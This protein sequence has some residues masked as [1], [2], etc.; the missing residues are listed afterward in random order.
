MRLLSGLLLGSLCLTLRA[1]VERLDEAPEISL[2][3]MVWYVP[4]ESGQSGYWVDGD[5]NADYR[6]NMGGV[7]SKPLAGTQKIDWKGREF[8]VT[9]VGRR[10]DGTL[11]IHFD[12]GLLFLTPQQ[13][14]SNGETIWQG[15]Y[16]VAGAISSPILFRTS[17]KGLAQGDVFGGMKR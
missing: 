2:H 8:D 3:R 11:I 13:A 9:F 1:E 15:T 16:T 6:S 7:R 10:D 5:L 12:A 4:H 17:P 14:S